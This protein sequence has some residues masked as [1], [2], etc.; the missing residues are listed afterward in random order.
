MK[1]LL[2]NIKEEHNERMNDLTELS[3][4]NNAKIKLLAEYIDDFEHRAISK[5]SQLILLSETE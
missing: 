2:D 1:A 4:S 3:K 5:V